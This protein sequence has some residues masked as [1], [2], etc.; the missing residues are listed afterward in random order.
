VNGPGQRTVNLDLGVD[1]DQV[2]DA[3]LA[4]AVGELVDARQPLDLFDVN[5]QSPVRCRAPPLLQQAM[6]LRRCD[7]S[8]VVQRHGRAGGAAQNERTLQQHDHHASEPG[9]VG[10]ADAVSV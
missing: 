3:Q 8:G 10:L 4:Q 5:H 2:V 1:A 6:Y 7:A 9:R